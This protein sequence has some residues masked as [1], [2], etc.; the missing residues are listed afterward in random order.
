MKPSED[1]LGVS[2]AE[3]SKDSM[4]TLV[5]SKIEGGSPVRYCQRLKYTVRSFQAPVGS[6]SDTET[7]AEPSISHFSNG[8][9]TCSEKFSCKLCGMEYRQSISLVRHMRIHTGEAPYTCELCGR[10]FRRKDWLVLHSSVHTGNKRKSIKRFSCD[11]CGKMFTGS[12]ALQSHLYKHRGERPFTCVHCD[13]TFF[14]QTNLKRHQIESHSDSKQFCCPVCGSGFSRLFSLQKHTRI[15][16]GKRPFSCPDCR[17]TFRNEY[18]MNMH[19]KRRHSVE[20]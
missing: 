9:K 13:K 10:G 7:E 15:H 6:S 5:L 1:F 20:S 3:S 11:Q 17:K 4:E 16:M 19:R 18:T 14:S 8:K 12:T 2:R